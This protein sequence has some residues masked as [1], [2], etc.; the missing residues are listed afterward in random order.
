MILLLHALYAGIMYLI[1]PRENM[2]LAFVLLL[3][4]AGLTIVSDH[5]Y[6]LLRWFPSITRGC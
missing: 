5:E 2:L 1:N 6:V 4:F 3:V